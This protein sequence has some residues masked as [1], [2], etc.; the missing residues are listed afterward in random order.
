MQKRPHI[1]EE[2]IRQVTDEIAA[3]HEIGDPDVLPRHYRNHM[4]G[5]ELAFKLSKFEGWDYGHEIDGD[6]IDELDT[7]S[8]R[9]DRIHREAVRKWFEQ[10]DIHPP[11]SVGTQIT[12]G[13]IDGIDE[14]GI[15]RYKVKRPE[16]AGK[17]S[18]LLV[19]FE[20][21]VPA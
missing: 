1:T 15:A 10:N 4:D 11:Y 20:D 8:H 16:D 9:V 18:W 3:K 5:I 13:V 2:M 21:A 17:E 6:F 12:Q 14:Y 19:N 7:I